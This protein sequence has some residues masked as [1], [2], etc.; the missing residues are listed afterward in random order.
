MVEL[1]VPGIVLQSIGRRGAEQRPSHA[2]MKVVLG[3]LIMATRANPRV[4]I[5]VPRSGVGGKAQP[6]PD[7]CDADALRGCIAARGGGHERSISRAGRIRPAGPSMDATLK[8]GCG[9]RTGSTADR[10]DGLAGS[11]W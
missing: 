3:D 7:P 2:G 8:T 10:A 1:V 11:W 4:E 6:N 9:S 5:V